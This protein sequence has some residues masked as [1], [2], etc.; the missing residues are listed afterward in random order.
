MRKMLKYQ[1]SW[2]PKDLF[3]EHVELYSYMIYVFAYKG[4]GAACVLL[5]EPSTDSPE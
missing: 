4:V 2:N 5:R 3:T 1:S